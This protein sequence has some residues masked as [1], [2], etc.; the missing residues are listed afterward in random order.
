MTKTSGGNWQIAIT[1]SLSL[2][3]NYRVCY[4][5]HQCIFLILRTILVGSLTLLHTNYPV[6]N[7]KHVLGIMKYL[8]KKFKQV[9]KRTL[10][11]L[12]YIISHYIRAY[13]S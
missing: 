9:R 7:T 13:F 6:T 3:L 1:L 5:T 11:I 8:S 4:L 2:F 10:M 12:Y